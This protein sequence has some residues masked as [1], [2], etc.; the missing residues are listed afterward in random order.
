MT[1]L[2]AWSILTAGIAI[3]LLMI[4]LRN[5]GGWLLLAVDSVAWTVYSAV[6][7][8]S[9]VVHILHLVMIAISVYFAYR[10]GKATMSAEELEV[11]DARA[12]APIARTDA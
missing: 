4:G 6:R 5:W 2:V 10:W 11:D 9:V 7:H 12:P 1:A 3:G 8:E